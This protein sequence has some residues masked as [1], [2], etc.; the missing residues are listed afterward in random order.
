MLDLRLSTTKRLIIARVFGDKGWAYFWETRF[1]PQWMP[2]LLGLGLGALLG[3]LI[4]AQVWLVVFL[5]VAMIPMAVLLSGYPFA[6]VLLWILITPFLVTP[7]N[8]MDEYIFWIPHRL[9]VPLALV[10]TLFPYLFRIKKEWPVRL[11]RSELAMLAFMGLT[12]L[13]SIFLSPNTLGTFYKIYDRFF[14]AYCLYLLMRL[15]APGEKELKL[16]LWVVFIQ[17]IIQ[18]A[19]GLLANFAPEVLPS[20]WYG[21]RAAVRTVGTFSHPARYTSVLGFC[22]PVIYQAAMHWKRGTIRWLFLSTFALGSLMVFLSFSKG[23]W[24]G[25]ILA[26]IGV[27]VLYPG[28][29]LRM[30]LILAILMAVFGAGLLADQLNYAMERYETNSTNERMVANV[31]MLRMIQ[32]KPLV[33]WGFN[34]LNSLI[35]KFVVRLDDF[36]ADANASHNTS[37]SIM[38]ELG[39][40]GYLLYI[41]P[42]I[43]WFILTIRAWSHMPREG[44]L[45]RSFVAMLWLT[46]MNQFVVG[47]F[48][49]FR[50]GADGLFVTCLWWATLGLIAS[51]VYPHVDS[52]HQVS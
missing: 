22:I 39:V 7:Q 1:L 36:A 45:G 42:F 2:L 21:A 13:S 24:L 50:N 17:I 25:G 34:N 16:L 43:W 10:A 12:I 11:G 33:G 19:V 28:P 26:L 30:A 49:D 6:G 35:G 52:E 4:T 48:S 51:L 15:T 47:N 20:R 27:L 37:L 14:I 46:V 23:S 3:F 5:L 40:V 8:R 38:A 41:F 29:T 9:M 31:A 18:S 32:A 44:F